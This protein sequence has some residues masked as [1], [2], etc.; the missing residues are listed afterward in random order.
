MYF[1][2]ITQTTVGFGDVSAGNNVLGQS[3]ITVHAFATFVITV[4]SLNAVTPDAKEN[5]YLILKHEKES[6]VTPFM[7]VHGGKTLTQAAEEK[8]LSRK[9]YLDQCGESACVE[10][11]PQQPPQPPQPEG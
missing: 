1:S 6:F 3:I 11:F 9:E 4:A 7:L 10:E 5:E 2:V 8:G